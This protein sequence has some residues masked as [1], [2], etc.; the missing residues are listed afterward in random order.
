MNRAQRLLRQ[1][2]QLYGKVFSF[3]LVEQSERGTWEAAIHFQ[4]KGK[5]TTE[6]VEYGDLETAQADFEILARQY[7]G[8]DEPLILIDDV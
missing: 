1:A 6:K 7:P 4:G 3:A 8:R 2:R 5:G